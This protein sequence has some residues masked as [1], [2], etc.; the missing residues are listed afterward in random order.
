MTIDKTLFEPQVCTMQTDTEIAYVVPVCE[1]CGHHLMRTT[2]GRMF[3]AVQCASTECNA[4]YVFMMGETPPVRL[5]TQEEI[6]A[7]LAKQQEVAAD[8]N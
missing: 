1:A 6:D 4:G 2:W 8:V 7:H 3:V 5:A